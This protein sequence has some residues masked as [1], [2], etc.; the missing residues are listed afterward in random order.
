MQEARDNSSGPM[1]D[2][3]D[4]PLRFRAGLDGQSIGPRQRAFAEEPIPQL[5]AHLASVER[6]LIDRALA[7][8]KQ[9]KTL[10][11]KLLGIPRTVLYRRL[12]ALGYS[13]Q[14][15]SEKVR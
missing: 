11:A 15:D 7:Q 12:E 14:V 6:D 4:L 3:K 9:N 8:A 2:V 1:I 10:A 5:E 13:D